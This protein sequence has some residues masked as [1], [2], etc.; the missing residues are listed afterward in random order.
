[1][2]KAPVDRVFGQHGGVGR[3]SNSDKVG[4]S[5]ERDPNGDK[6]N[7]VGNEIGE[8]PECQPA[9]QRDGCLLLF[10]VHEESEPERAEKQAPK[11]PRLVQCNLTRRLGMKDQRPDAWLTDDNRTKNDDCSSVGASA[12]DYCRLEC[13]SF[14]ESAIR[15]FDHRFYRPR[16]PEKYLGGVGKQGR[17]RAL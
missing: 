1:M 16:M 3:C 10:A 7:G 5:Y 6:K 14:S 12:I 11:N 8:D 2:A 9:D 4:K 15:F 13:K 17:R